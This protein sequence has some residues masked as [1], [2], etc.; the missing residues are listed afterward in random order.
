ML[1]FTATRPSTF[2]SIALY[3]LTSASG[4]ISLVKYTFDWP[5]PVTVAIIA[6]A[7]IK[8]FFLIIITHVLCVI[9]NMVIFNVAK[10]YIFLVIID[11]QIM[12]IA[13]NFTDFDNFSL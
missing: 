8:I 2:R 9:A 10:L 5:N 12:D 11:K 1:I 3:I 6:T 4:L 13:T 7:K